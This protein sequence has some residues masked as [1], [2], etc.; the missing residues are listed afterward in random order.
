MSNPGSETPIYQS[1]WGLTKGQRISMTKKGELQAI[2]SERERQLRA[3]YH[4]TLEDFDRLLEAQNNQCAVCD[5]DLSVLAYVPY[6]DHSHSTGIVRGIVCAGCNTI[7]GH[8]EKGL[9]NYKKVMAYLNPSIT[10]PDDVE[11]R[12]TASTG[13]AKGEKLARFSLIPPKAWYELAKLYGVG[14][15]KYGDANWLKGYPWHLSYDALNR[16]LERFWMGESID[17]E[18]NAHHLMSVIFHAIAMYTFEEL[19][20]EFDDRHLLEQKGE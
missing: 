12:V 6:V 11:T 13:G 14:A 8:M 15:Q 17:P 3:R 19:H 2:R 16:H 9:N 18:T 20:P 10:P 5:I 1:L 7:V 4:M